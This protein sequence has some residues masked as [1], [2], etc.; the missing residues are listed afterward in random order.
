[1]ATKHTY[2]LFLS[3]ASEDKDAIARPLYEALHAEG[4]DVWFD[5][6]VL[7]IGDSLSGKIDEGLAKCPYGIVILS[8]SFFAKN[9]PKKELAGLAAKEVAGTQT[10]VL[11]IWHDIDHATIL[12]HSPPLADKKAAKSSDGIPVIVKMILEVVRPS[13]TAV[14]LHKRTQA[15]ENFAASSSF[16][17]AKQNAWELTRNGPFTA[18]EIDRIFLAATINNQIYLPDETKKPIRELISK[19][20]HLASTSMRDRVLE[21]FG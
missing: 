12:K 21:K 8:P 19:W 16:Y 10:V 4:V 2:D 18:A 3:H 6:A 11:P 15:I 20:G 5:E 17:A 7:K 9:W 1:V 13:A 14:S